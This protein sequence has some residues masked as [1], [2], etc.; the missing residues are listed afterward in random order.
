MCSNLVFHEQFQFAV[1]FQRK[2]QK[3]Y[4]LW[5]LWSIKVKFITIEKSHRPQ[6]FC[7]FLKKFILLWS[8]YILNCSKV[9]VTSFSK[10]SWKK[11]IMVF[12]KHSP[13]SISKHFFFFLLCAWVLKK[14]WLRY[15]LAQTR[16]PSSDYNI[17]FYSAKHSV[18]ES[19]LTGKKKHNL[20]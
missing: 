1:S 4:T 20:P 7:L 8:M 13:N 9:V 12:V 3:L 15:N 18:Y 11:C 16:T 10:E 2:I 14:L 17:Y 19:C 6:T 5:A